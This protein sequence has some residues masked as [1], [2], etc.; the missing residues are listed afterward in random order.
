MFK[1]C[2]YCGK[3]RWHTEEMLLE[4][5]YRAEPCEKCEDKVKKTN[6]E[7]VKNGTE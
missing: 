4:D 5:F 7:E 2:I 1:T 6:R 3:E